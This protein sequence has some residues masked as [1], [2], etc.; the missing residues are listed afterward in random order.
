MKKFLA[1]IIC[2]TTVFFL[3]SCDNL[4]ITNEMQI[5]IDLYKSAVEKS[6]QK[7]EGNISVTSVAVDSAIEFKT[8]KSEI[9]FIY[10]VDDNAVSFER[11][12]RLNGKEIAKYKCNGTEVFSYNYETSNWDEKTEQN[13]E[14][15]SASENPFITLS[16][17]RVDTNGKMRMDYME[18]IRNYKEGEY[19]VVEFTLDDSTVSNVLQYYKA[20]GIVRKSAGHTRTYYIDS[21]GYIA[22]IVVATVQL[23][24]TNGEEG[25]YSTEMTVICK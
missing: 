5:A 8:T 12:D 16:L 15:M 10:T 25:S 7:S 18:N 22:K 17:F 20:D 21:D 6:K 9:D 4:K 19:T 1:F 2:I 24:Y 13:K 11:S 23:M 14:F 3:C